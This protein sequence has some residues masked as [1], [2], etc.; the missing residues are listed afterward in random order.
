MEK[1]QLFYHGGSKGIRG[2]TGEPIIDS[3][4]GKPFASLCE[5]LLSVVNFFYHGGNKGIR[6]GT[7]GFTVSKI[8]PVCK[9]HFLVVK[10]WHLQ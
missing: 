2:G 5:D 4:F 1:R 10:G 9:P 3:G 7:G 6:G 8:T